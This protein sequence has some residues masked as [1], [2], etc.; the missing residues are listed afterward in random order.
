MQNVRTVQDLAGVASYLCSAAEE[1][2][3]AGYD[4]WSSEV[5]QLLDIIAAEIAWLQERDVTGVV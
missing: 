4:A 2:T 5:K 3:A 1:L